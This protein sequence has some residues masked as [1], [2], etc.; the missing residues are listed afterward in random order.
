M[1]DDDQDQE[2]GNYRTQQDIRR[3]RFMALG[4]DKTLFMR[5]KDY[6][7]RPVLGDLVTDEHRQLVMDMRAGG[8]KQ[9]TIATVIGMSKASLQKLFPVE[10]ESAVELTEAALALSLTHSGMAGDTPAALGYLKSHP[11]LKWGS[12][13]Q[14]T[15]KD[16]KELVP[17]NATQ[18]EA[19][20]ILLAGILSELSTDKTKFKRPGK[21]KPKAAKVVES[22]KLKPVARKGIMRRAKGD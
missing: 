2:H 15:G 10:L 6:R 7:D 14:I 19:N 5:L 9:E 17:D 13:S 12:K 3:E 8:M 20:Q 16:G 4:G 1:A 22:D 11:E 21:E 18:L